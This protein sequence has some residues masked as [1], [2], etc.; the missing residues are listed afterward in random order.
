VDQVFGFH[1]FSLFFFSRLETIIHPLKGR[2][3][4]TAQIH[5]EHEVRLTL[6]RAIED[7][8]EREAPPSRF[9]QLNHTPGC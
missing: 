6:H 4:E 7:K 9:L 2:E 1:F 5:P 3:R 8:R